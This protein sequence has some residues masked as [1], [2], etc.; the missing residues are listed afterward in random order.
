MAAFMADYELY[1]IELTKSYTK[2]EWREDVKKA[3][4]HLCTPTPTHTG[5][6][7]WVEC[8]VVTA[9]PTVSSALV[10]TTLSCIA[11]IS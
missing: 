11:V 2:V 4:S 5:H 1:Q 9:Q 7:A 8:P 6:R 3:S 10:F